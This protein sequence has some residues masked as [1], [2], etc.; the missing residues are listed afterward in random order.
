VGNFRF[1][2]EF[3]AHESKQLVTCIKLHKILEYM[4]ICEPLL[5]GSLAWSVKLSIQVY[6]CVTPTQPDTLLVEL[7]KDWIVKLAFC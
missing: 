6:V 4:M 5:A 3:K 1:V 2:E 7:H